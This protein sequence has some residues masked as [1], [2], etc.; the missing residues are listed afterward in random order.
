MDELEA[1]AKFIP[2]VRETCLL[3]FT[4]T[5]L[6]EVDQDEDLAISG[7]GNP[8]RLDRSGDHRE[9]P[10]RGSESFCQSVVL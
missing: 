10:R 1:W 2:A 6:S 9:E 7:F 3:A 5:W 4:E 8:L